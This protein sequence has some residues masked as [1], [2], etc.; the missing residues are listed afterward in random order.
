LVRLI[1]VAGELAGEPFYWISKEVIPDIESSSTT[2]VARLYYAIAIVA[3]GIV[4]T[5][6]FVV[7]CDSDIREC[8]EVAWVGRINRNDTYGRDSI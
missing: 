2:F 3:T 8:K 5:C 4:N 7:A 1:G 6:E